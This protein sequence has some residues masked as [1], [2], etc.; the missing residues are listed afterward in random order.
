MFKKMIVKK[1]KFA[2]NM[3]VPV[4]LMDFLIQAQGP[5]GEIFL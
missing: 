2:Q 4:S 5:L 1:D 3:E